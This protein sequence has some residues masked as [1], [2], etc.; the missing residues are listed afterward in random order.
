MSSLPIYSSMLT[1]ATHL[2]ENAALVVAERDR[3]G[4]LLAADRPDALQPVVERRLE[5]VR[6][7]VPDSDCACRSQNT[8]P[9]KSVTKQ[10]HV[11]R[12]LLCY[13]AKLQITECE[14]LLSRI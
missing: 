10:I 1:H 6:V 3:V 14:C 9:F 7:G 12:H 11:L 13:S 4:A 5:A 8:T 2:D